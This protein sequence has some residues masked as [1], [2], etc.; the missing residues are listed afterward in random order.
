MLTIGLHL[1][2]KN[3]DHH[4]QNHHNEQ[5]PRKLSILMASHR[6]FYR[7]SN[8]K[9]TKTIDTKPKAKIPKKR[10]KSAKGFFQK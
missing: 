4:I 6:R 5:S 3:T 8:Q 1:S 7:V 2:D 10:R 9:I